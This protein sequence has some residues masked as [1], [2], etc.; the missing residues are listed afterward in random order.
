MCFEIHI[1]RLFYKLIWAVE[2]L[3]ACYDAGIVD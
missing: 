3:S 1:E 2:E